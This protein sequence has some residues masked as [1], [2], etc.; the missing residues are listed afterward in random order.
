MLPDAKIKIISRQSNN[1]KE[2]KQLIYV[3]E[4]RIYYENITDFFE[5][6]KFSYYFKSRGLK[7]G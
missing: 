5:I 7:A 3:F 4:K 6:N 1:Y 2:P